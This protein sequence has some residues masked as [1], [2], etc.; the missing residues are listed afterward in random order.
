MGST[1]LGPARPFKSNPGTRVFS[2]FVAKERL[3][4]ASCRVHS[5]SWHSVPHHNHER[6]KYS[7]F[8]TLKC[9]SR[10]LEV[11][12]ATRHRDGVKASVALQALPWRHPL[13]NLDGASAARSPI[14]RQGILVNS[15]NGSA[16][17]GRKAVKCFLRP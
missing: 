15:W 10:H 4:T 6:Q 17:Q 5:K 3:Q 7:G 11:C 2:F 8:A 16:G 1:V 9:F 12:E 14:L 13:A